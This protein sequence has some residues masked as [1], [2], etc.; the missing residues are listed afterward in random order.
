MPITTSAKK[1]LRGSAKKRDHNLVRKNAIQKEVKKI[2]KLVAGKSAKEAKAAL[3]AAYKALD[4]A[5][6]TGFLKKNAAART[7]SRLSAMIKKLGK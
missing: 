6:K 7:K 4:K 5:V 3:P 2:K 1:A